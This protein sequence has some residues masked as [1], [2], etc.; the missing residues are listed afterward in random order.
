MNRALSLGLLAALVVAPPIRAQAADV[1]YD[2]TTPTGVIHGS[3]RMPAPAER[4]KPPVVLIIAGSGPTDRNGNSGAAVTGNT[5]KLLADALAERGIASVRYDKRG[6][7]ASRAAGP[8]EIDMRFETGVADAAAWVEQLRNDARFK[9]VVIAGHSEGSLVGML[10]ARQARADGFVSISGVASRA[11]DVLR[12]QLKPQLASLP[13]LAAASESVLKSLEAGQTVSPLPQPIPMVPGLASLYRAS[14]QPYLISWFRYDPAKEFAMLTRPAL[15]IQG[16]TDI[17][18][19]VDEAKALA[20]A[21][22]DATL[23]IVDGMNHVLKMAPADRAAN[24]ATYTQPDLPLAPAVPDAIATFVSGL[25]L[26]PHATGERKSPRTVTAA[27]V[28]GVR[29]AVEY[30][31]LGVRGRKIWGALVPWNKQW[32]AGADEATTL[33]TS[34][35]IVLGAPGNSLTVPAGDHTLFAMPSEDHFLL[36]VNN[37]TFQFH[38][39]YDASK[40]LGRVKMSLTTL[41]QPVE[42]LRWE[43]VASPGGGVLKFAWSD[44]E[45]SVP[46]R[47]AAAPSPFP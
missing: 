34:A 26:P 4:V 21:K 35:P 40:D 37:Q 14:V 41:E 11:S 7:A 28:D 2:L 17:Q 8:A 32:M 39:Q 1:P 13:A 6:I 33:T 9:S 5:Y 46:F 18:V 36:L 44:R 29:L 3:L 10:A 42:L 38:T 24:V 16:T 19:S 45:Y 27:E 43:I 47:S 12:A 31:Q 23:K 20:A 25:F 30:G 22:P 15:V